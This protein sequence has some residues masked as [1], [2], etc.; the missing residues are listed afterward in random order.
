MMVKH[1]Y[2]PISFEIPMS[3][4]F[5]PLDRRDLQEHMVHKAVGHLFEVCTLLRLFP[6]P[7]RH[8][9]VD[10]AKALF[11]LVARRQTHLWNKTTYT[12]K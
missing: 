11:K 7:D 8:L 12:V 2:K 1:L 6:P 9:M 5:F 10:F 4:K 3:S